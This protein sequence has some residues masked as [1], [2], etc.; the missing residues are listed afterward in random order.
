MFLLPL[1]H[2]VSLWC[3]GFF[4][5]YSLSVQIT[6]IFSTPV[7]MVVFH[8]DIHQILQY[9]TAKYSFS[10]KQANMPKIFACMIGFGHCLCF[11]T[12]LDLVMYWDVKDGI[13][14]QIRD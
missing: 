7:F 2:F 13:F 6:D 9:A 8:T 1:P 12:P 14:M 10:V 3:Y 11:V 5:D 4:L